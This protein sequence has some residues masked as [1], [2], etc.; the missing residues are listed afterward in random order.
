[1]IP[2]FILWYSAVAHIP[3]PGVGVIGG[4]PRVG[5]WDPVWSWSGFRGVGMVV[6][7]FNMGGWDKSIPVLARPVLSFSISDEQGSLSVLCTFTLALWTKAGLQMPLGVLIS[8]S[9]PSDDVEDSLKL[10]EEE[11]RVTASAEVSL[12][13]IPTPMV[14]TTVESRLDQDESSSNPL[15]EPDGV[16]ASCSSLERWAGVG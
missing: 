5:S 15:V 11:S 6:L 10:D 9:D 14:L 13:E 4:D 2:A 7:G 3:G 16:E 12:S 1:M 8:T